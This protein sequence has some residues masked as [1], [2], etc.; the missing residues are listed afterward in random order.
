M[1]RVNHQLMAFK[2]RG[3]LLTNINRLLS[4]Q[5]YGDDDGFYGLEVEVLPEAGAGDVPNKVGCWS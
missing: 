1:S 4:S 5:L 3:L 2:D